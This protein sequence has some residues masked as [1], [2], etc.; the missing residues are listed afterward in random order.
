[1]RTG[2]ESGIIGRTA[3]K[4]EAARTLVRRIYTTCRVV[5]CTDEEFGRRAT[6]VAD[7][8]PP[9]D[10]NQQTNGWIVERCRWFLTRHGA[11]CA[12]TRDAGM[13][14]SGWWK[15]PDYERCYHLSV[16]FWD[17]ESGESS[18]HDH[19]AAAA[20]IRGVYGLASAMLWCEPPYS[21]SGK[22]LDVWHYRLFMSADWK[23]P[24]IPR[25]E[26]YSRDFIPAGWK[27]WSAVQADLAVVNQGG[28]LSFDHIA[29]GGAR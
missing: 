11:L 10:G 24:L 17:L 5:N 20:I 19:K 1:M 13:H 29:A 6:V 8:H 9:Y 16:S 21:E 22:R 4:T 3:L 27:T 25:K 28:E 26:V 12:F 7:S 14:T 2:V 18:D 23:A 15:N